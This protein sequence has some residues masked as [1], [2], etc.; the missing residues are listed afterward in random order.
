MNDDLTPGIPADQP[1]TSTATAV[2]PPPPA[3]PTTATAGARPP[4]RRNWLWVVAVLIVVAA[5]GVGGFLGYRQMTSQRVALDRL[6]KA[7]TLVERADGVVLDVDEVVRSEVSAELGAKAAELLD[8]TPDAREDL[9]QAVDL[10]EDAVPDLPVQDA[11]EAVALRA[12]AQARLAMLDDADVIL[13][14]NAK[15]A[16]ALDPATRGW[17]LVLEAEN[18]A[19]SAVAEYNKL[20]KDAVAKSKQIT[21]QAETKL[22]DAK[23]LFEEAGDAFPDADFSAYITYIDGK[24]AA[25]AISKQANDAYLADKPADANTLSTKYNDAEKKL[26]TQANALPSSPAQVVADAYTSVAGEPTD[27]YMAAR[28]QATAADD[29]YKAL[30]AD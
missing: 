8:E 14:A 11:E 5:L 1:A 9:T 29:A 7:T 18:L 15:A 22:R 2:A 3:P 30:T 6:E 4:R 13:D 26:V 17:G 28:E 20:T 27:Q 19:D 12:S 25:L 10:L 23:T 24:I 21:E 16:A